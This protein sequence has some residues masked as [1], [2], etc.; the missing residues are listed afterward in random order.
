MSCDCISFLFLILHCL[1]Q[2]PAPGFCTSVTL[3]MRHESLRGRQ[4]LYSE[5]SFANTTKMLCSRTHYWNTV[6]HTTQTLARAPTHT[7]THT[8]ETV[9]QTLLKHS[10]THTTD[11]LTKQI[12]KHCHIH[13]CNALTHTTKNLSHTLQHFSSVCEWQFWI[14]DDPSY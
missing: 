4:E 10:Y 12:L 1:L 11:K 7:H 6:I 3:Y 8:T 2:P 9:S 13:N 14:P 5:L